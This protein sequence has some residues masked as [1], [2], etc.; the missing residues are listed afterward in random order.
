MTTRSVGTC[1]A[2]ALCSLFL[3]GEESAQAKDVDITD[4]IGGGCV[5][6][7]ATIRAGGY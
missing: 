4:V 2:L 5:P 6:D 7:S 1:F 3:A